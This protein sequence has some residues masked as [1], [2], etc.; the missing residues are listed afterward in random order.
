MYRKS[1][2]SI[3]AA[4]ALVPSLFAQNEG[5]DK[6]TLSSSFETNTTYYFND[7][8]TG[9]MAPDMK[10]GS[11]NYLKVDYVKGG[12]SFGTQVELYLPALSGYFPMSLS[13]QRMARYDYYAGFN[14]KGWDIR[15]GSLFEQ[16]GSG[17]ILRTYED[18]TLGVNN[19][20]KGARV[21]YTFGDYLTIKGLYGLVRQDFDYDYNTSSSVAAADL[22]FS[23]SN[24]AK[25]D[26][27]DLSVEGSVVNKY[28]SLSGEATSP[29]TTGYS[30]RL[31]FGTH[32]FILKGEY[33]DRKSDPGFYNANDTTRN[34]AIQVELG[35]SGYGF[36]ALAT[37]RQLKNA[38][39]QGYRGKTE[40]F[41]LIN[42]VPAL[43]QQHTYMLATMNP[44]SPQADEIGGQVDLF[45]N[46][47]KGSVIGGKKGMKVHANFSTFYGKYLEVGEL[48]AN[49]SLLFRDLTID[50]ERWWGKNVKMILYYTWQTFNPNTIG[51]GN[52]ENPSLL[53]DSHTVVAD[54]TYKINRKNSLRFEV[55]H[56]YTQ[57]DHKGWVAALVE[58]NLAPRWSVSVQDMWNYGETNTHYINGSVGYSYGKVR[59]ALNA[60]R[61]KEGYL[62][63]GGVCRM[64]PAYTG[65]NLS[66]IVMM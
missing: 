59:A 7:E 64:T 43:T 60:G 65:V 39:F 28:E 34:R 42:Y 48:S 62:C 51:K 19:A 9:A 10:F 44:Y 50:L 41:T 63:S 21:A 6:G 45:Y 16:F 58:Y 15:V 54:V 52:P 40:M 26:N 57:Q 30:A 49:T 4:M 20:L 46:F 12:F 5:E 37:F 33:M 18:R 17:L 13:G 24:A 31:N 8:K 27:I 3:L 25:L 56:L 14:S 36:G 23:I 32:G 66:L 47:K 1:I 38:S 35:Y 55:Q 53:W 11:N 61:F 29:L 2:V 22:S